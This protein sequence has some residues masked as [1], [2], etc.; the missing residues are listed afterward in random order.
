MGDIASVMLLTGLI[1]AAA[2]VIHYWLQ[3]KWRQFQR[4]VNSCA[5]GL[6]DLTDIEAQHTQVA[7]H[8]RTVC[9]PKRE[10]IAR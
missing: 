6:Y 2:T 7:V 5:C 1:L 3:D 4:G 8:G 10:W 9:Q